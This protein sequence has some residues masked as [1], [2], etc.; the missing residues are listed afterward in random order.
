MSLRYAGPMLSAILLLI[1]ALAC[2][3][4]AEPTPRPTYTLYPTATSEPTAPPAPTATIG[5]T[6][7]PAPT[8]AA[9]PEL[10]TMLV[11]PPDLILPTDAPRPTFAFLST[12]VPRPTS[13]LRLIATK[14]PTVSPTSTVPERSYESANLE[15]FSGLA[16]EAMTR[17]NAQMA[18]GDFPAALRSYKEAQKHHDRPS[19]VIQNRIGTAYS[20]L[21]VYPQAIRHFSNA[22]DAIDAN[23][24][25]LDRVNRA[26]SYAFN[27]NCGPAIQDAKVA[28]TQEGEGGPGFHTDAEANIVLAFCYA[29][30]GEWTAVLQHAEA[31][32]GFATEHN[33][34]PAVLASLVA[35]RDDAKL[36]Q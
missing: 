14:R 18:S 31:A 3:P 27:G 9:M 16:Y 35:M 7:I 8:A 5:L 20:N 29:E 23:D 2:G 26:N 10:P 28:L 19:S 22:I 17:G 6:F 1:L 12:A 15:Y 34:A 33:Y 32:L 21:E 36:S 30:Q 13:G 24:Q 4:P 11:L 25:A